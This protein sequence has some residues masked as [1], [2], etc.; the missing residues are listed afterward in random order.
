MRGVVKRLRRKLGEAAANPRHTF[1]E[2]RVG[3][4]M[5]AETEEG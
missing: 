5:A 4:W 3:Y 2:P 1:I